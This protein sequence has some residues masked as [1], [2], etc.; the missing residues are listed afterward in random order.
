MNTP[1]GIM[2]PWLTGLYGDFT[3]N[4]SVSVEDLAMFAE[5]WMSNNCVL[6]SAIDLDGDCSVDFY[7]FSQFA[8][9]WM[10]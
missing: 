5:N 4:G 8:Q 9:N 6:T 7:E 1:A 10:K 3:G 2:S